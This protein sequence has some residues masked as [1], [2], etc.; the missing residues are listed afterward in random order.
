MEVVALVWFGIAG[1]AFVFALSLLH[2][3]Y[4]KKTPHAVQSRGSFAMFAAIMV[5]FGVGAAF[6]GIASS[7][8]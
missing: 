2:Q 4:I 1:G 5:L 6:A 7:G 3:R 8:G